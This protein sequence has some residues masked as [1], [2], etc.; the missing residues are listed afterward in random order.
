MSG[1]VDFLVRKKPS[2][3]RLLCVLVWFSTTGTQAQTLT[4][5]DVVERV[6]SRPDLVETLAAR[7]DAER[8]RAL[9]SA[10]RPNPQLI[11]MREQTYNS[12]GTGED[13]ASI[14]QTI[15]LGGRYHLNQ[16]AGEAR[17]RAREYEGRSTQLGVAAE[18][19]SRFYDCLYRERRIVAL[20]QLR[21]QIEQALTVVQKR[22]AR[23]DAA[24]YDRRRLERERTVT[25]ARLE[26]ERAHAAGARHRL[27]ALLGLDLEGASLSGALLPEGAPPER[28]ELLSAAAGRPDLLALDEEEAGANLSARAASRAWVPELR[29]EAGYKGVGLNAGGRT[30]GFLAGG[31]LTLPLWDR[32]AGPRR[33]AEAEARA[34]SAERRLLESQI[35]GEVMGARQ[36]AEQLR[37]ASLQFRRDAAQVSADLL[38]MAA[39]GYQGGELGLLELLD[40]YRGAVE[41]QLTALELELASRHALIELN[42]LTGALQ[43]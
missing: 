41:D 14:A 23:G 33:T 31:Y 43:P 2:V 38:R 32:G 3:G 28:K 18:A 8:G 15:H 27:G 6:L 13:Y 4:E 26:A 35:D 39:A 5:R 19:R 1:F 34:L 17:A 10:A 36:E 25:V 37:V 12:N 7:V 22:E 24:L 16:Q 9:S 29:L 40:A 11:Y 20:E 30:D 42:R 21:T